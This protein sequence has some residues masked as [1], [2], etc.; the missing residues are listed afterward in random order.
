MIIEL[1]LGPSTRI[2][3]KGFDLVVVK[4]I[5]YTEAKLVG[6]GHNIAKHLVHGCGGFRR[7]DLIAENDTDILLQCQHCKETIVVNRETGEPREE[8]KK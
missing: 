6:W 2:R 4:T 3:Y 8:G 1:E 5:N 7:C